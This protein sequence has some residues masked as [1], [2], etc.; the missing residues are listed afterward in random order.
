M[1]QRE[2]QVQQRLQCRAVPHP[3]SVCPT[4]RFGSF[5]N[6]NH[7]PPHPDPGNWPALTLTQC[8]ALCIPSAESGFPVTD[9]DRSECMPDL[10][11]LGA[12]RNLLF[13]CRGGINVLSILIFIKTNA[14]G[15]ITFFFLQIL[16]HI[17]PSCFF[18]IFSSSTLF[19]EV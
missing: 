3:H 7:C 6:R 2:R 13:W 11:H 15:M 9:R 19:A 5:G 12:E 4:H 1:L 8:S 18:F 17:L 16:H 10:T 14:I